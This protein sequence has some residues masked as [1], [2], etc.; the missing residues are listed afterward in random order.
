MV[1]D[2]IEQYL[3][4]T[5]PPDY[6]NRYFSLDLNDKREIYQRSK[7]EQPKNW[8]KIPFVTT[9]DI[10]GVGLGNE[11]ERSIGGRVSDSQKINLRMATEKKWKKAQRFNK[12]YSRGYLRKEP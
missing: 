11:K 7:K 3:E 12:Q 9:K 2:E 1:D 8:V 4:S 10:W 6:E 5:V